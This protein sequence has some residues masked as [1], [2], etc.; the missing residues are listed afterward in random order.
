LNCGSH[1]PVEEEEGP[2]EELPG[3]W[4]VGEN[5]KSLHESDSDGDSSEDEDEG[6]GIYEL[7]GLNCD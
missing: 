4:N 6:N 7:R 5:S 2:G 1:A 3:E